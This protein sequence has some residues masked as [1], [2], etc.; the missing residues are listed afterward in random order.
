MSEL[1]KI[2]LRKQPTFTKQVS[3]HIESKVKWLKNRFHAIVEMCKE[4]GCSW[5]DAEKKIS[6]EKQWY[7]DWCKVR[8]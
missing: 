4:S 1:L 2:I 5:N 8:N 3:P 7:D 6:C